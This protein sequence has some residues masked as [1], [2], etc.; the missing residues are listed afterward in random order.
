MKKNVFRVKDVETGEEEV[1]TM[2]QVLYE[3]NRDR[4]DEWTD[5]DE[6]DWFEGWSVWVEECGIYSMIEATIEA[7]V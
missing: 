1:W 5:Y 4:S 6:T 2:E 3:I 7:T